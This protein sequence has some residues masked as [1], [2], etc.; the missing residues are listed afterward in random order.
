[1][2]FS[3]YL[4]II[5]KY[6]NIYIYICIC[7]VCVSTPQDHSSENDWNHHRKAVSF[8]ALSFDTSPNSLKFTSVLHFTICFPSFF[9]TK[10]NQLSTSCSTQITCSTE[11]FFFGE[12]GWGNYCWF[13]EILHHQRWWLSPLFLRF[14]HPRWLGMG[15]LNHQ[16][17]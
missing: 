7:I 1:M 12:G 14:N 17:R 13:P 6:I 10:L 4:D 9:P 15:F 5:N 11:P 3:I 8:V 2:D 16:Q